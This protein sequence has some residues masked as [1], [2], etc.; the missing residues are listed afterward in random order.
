[1]D[2][3]KPGFVVGAF[4]FNSK[5]RLLLIKSP[6]WGGKFI[7]PGGHVD[8]GESIVDAVK[9]EVKE[10]TGLDV[11]VICPLGNVGEVL[12][13]EEYKTNRHL[14]YMQ[15]V[16]IA[17]SNN[18]VPDGREAVDFKWVTLDETKNMDIAKPTDGVIDILR[19]LHGIK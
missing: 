6:K 14:V 16:C 13:F 7:V 4:I 10:E 8:Y 18:V 12:S 11:E 17:S 1:M 3:K 9:R 5:G 2:S 19:K 15:Y